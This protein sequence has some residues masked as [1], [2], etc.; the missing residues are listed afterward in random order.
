MQKFTRITAVAAPLPLANVDTDMIIPAQYM[1]SLT[2]TGL[3]RHLFRELRF[4]GDTS[5][6]E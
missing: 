2:R 6:R 1:K 4:A 5:E 3:G